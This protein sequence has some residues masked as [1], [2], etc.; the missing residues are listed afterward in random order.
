MIHRSSGAVETQH[1]I[2]DKDWKQL[3]QDSRI[4]TQQLLE[5]VGL[6]AH[7]QAESEAERLFELRVPQPYIDKIEAGNPHDP[8]LLQVLPQQRE[9][10]PMP[11]FVNDPL[12]ERQFS[13]V[14]GIIHKYQNRV[15]LIASQACAIHC[16]YCFRR[17]FPYAEHRQSRQQWLEALNY[18]RTHPEIDEVILSGGDPLVLDNDY[19]AWLLGE[20]ADIAHI[21]HLRIHSRLLSSLP[22]RVDKGLLDI[23]TACKKPLVIVVHCNHPNEV[24]E[25]LQ[26]ALRQLRNAGATLLNQSVLLKDINDNADVL[27]ELSHALFAAGTLPYYLFLLDRVAGAGHFE[28]SSEDAKR[29][30][31]RLSASVSGYLLP[32]LMVEIPGQVA[33]TPVTITE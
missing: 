23:V 32:R 5:A 33:K 19:L 7:P 25:H 10:D 29:V 27:A 16:R 6:R 26:V 22:Q 13:P 30:Y 1:I 28:V 15:L 11:G 31:T 20:L 2:S 21:K 12:Q 14:R 24:D 17:H 9:F 3:L 8:L 18:V 4:T